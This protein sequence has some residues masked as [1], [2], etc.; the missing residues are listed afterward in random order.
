MSLAVERAPRRLSSSPRFAGRACRDPRGSTAF[1]TTGRPGPDGYARRNGIFAQ[2]DRQHIEKQFRDV[3]TMILPELA[4]AEA[5]T[6]DP[7][8]F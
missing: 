3:T 2:P 1:A 5:R 4:D 7:A 8:W 6:T